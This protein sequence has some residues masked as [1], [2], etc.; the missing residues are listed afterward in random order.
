[1]STIEITRMEDVRVGDVVTLRW[2]YAVGVT[3]TLEGP[4]QHGGV[5]GFTVTDARFVSATRE[6]PE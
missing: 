2:E 4:M 6:V 3:V 5:G 1:M